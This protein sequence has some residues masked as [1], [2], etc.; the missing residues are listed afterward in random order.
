MKRK[1]I[2]LL[3]A[4]MLIFGVAAA[5]AEGNVLQ[6]DRKAGTV[7]AGETFR[8]G[9]TREG[10]PAGGELTYTSSNPKVATVDVTGLVRGVAKGKATITATVAVEGRTY[11]AQMAVTVEKK[12]ESI[13]VNAEKLPIYDAG[14][15]AVSALLRE[16]GE[17]LPVL[18]VS[19]KKSVSLQAAALPKDASNRKVTMTAQDPSVLQVKSG[20]VTGLKAGETVLTI[21]S[22]SNPEVCV[23]YRALV[24]QPMKK[25]TVEAS[26]S[27]VTVGG[28]ITL[29][30]TVSPA[31]ASVTKV[32]W[33]GD[34]KTLKVDENGVVT[35]L[36]HG[37]GR[38][39]ATAADGSNVRAS[40]SVK[41]EQRPE[42]LS[43]SAGKVTV[44][45]GRNT[46]V[47]ATVAPKDADNRKVR[48]TSSDESVATVS[49]DG[50]ITGV[51]PGACTVTCICEA[52]KSVSAVVAVQ[53][54]QSV[55]KLS[56]TDKTAV[57]YAGETLQLRW[58]TEPANATNAGIA[59]TSSNEK[60]A[61]V[62]A[63]GLVRGVS[64][65]QTY[66]NAVTTDGSNRK[67]RIQVKVGLHV[68]GVQ[69][70]RQHA[71]IDLRETATAGATLQPKDATNKNMTWV[72]SDE[73]VVTATGKTNEKMKLKGVG[74]GEAT[75]TGTTE[76]GGYQTSIQVT[77]GNFDRSLS[78][79]DFGWDSRGNF[80]LSV[81]NNSNFT[82][83][84]IT[85]IVQMYDATVADNPE[86]PIN[87][88]NGS[89]KVEV[90]WS[91]RLYPG[92]S[93]GANHWKMSAYQAPSIGVGRTR[94]IVTLHSFQIENDWI[95]VIREKNRQWKEY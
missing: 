88:K 57:T 23:R 28:Q 4:V 93:T 39:T 59:F 32:I 83:T 71:Y 85:A 65:G 50:R 27:S 8:T 79:R 69:M 89:N 5:F 80:W 82:I 37:I 52:A 86:I 51:A 77:V 43:L 18:L 14:D 61:T 66:I 19:V 10:A 40:F 64:R 42:S 1:L 29:K 49:K 21:A 16:G 13:Q 58:T 87:T 63:N 70:V 47:K 25:L 56:F 44:D 38:V 24:I 26:E 55:K 75:V 6:F 20:A 76:D 34:G 68:T 72:S 95:K 48:W 30:A 36:K 33:S 31:D 9:L 12:A 54:Q 78:F 17:N 90:V 81:R 35:G 2:P 60:I 46:V 74:Y 3:I 15:P 11:R 53:V 67:A 7:F 62:D 22:V 73:S 41:V 94:G 91:G 92:E 84:R 45:V